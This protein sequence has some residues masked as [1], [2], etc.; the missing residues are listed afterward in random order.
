MHSSRKSF[1]ASPRSRYAYAQ[2]G[3]VGPPGEI[4]EGV[5]VPVV[6]LVVDGA[7]AHDADEVA[8]EEH[9]EDVLG[10]Q[11]HVAVAHD[12]PVEHA[13]EE[14]ARLRRE[15][16]GL[17]DGPDAAHGPSD[18]RARMAGLG[19]AEEDEGEKECELKDEEDSAEGGR[20]E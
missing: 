20:D 7:R 12:E 18:D 15:R 11:L 5:E 9:G 1:Y 16:I 10:G 13:D 3:E 8:A 17:D 19:P 6:V 4:G 2:R 14:V